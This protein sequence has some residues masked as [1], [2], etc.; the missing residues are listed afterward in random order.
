MWGS[1]HILNLFRSLLVCLDMA[2][3]GRNLHTHSVE[4]LANPNSH[5]CFVLAHFS[6][7]LHC[8]CLA[9][10]PGYRTNFPA[11]FSSCPL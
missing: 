3:E 11:F 7:C 9:P 2:S 1:P 10:L 4:S 5:S 8:H 6:H